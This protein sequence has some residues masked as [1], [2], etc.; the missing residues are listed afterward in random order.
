MPSLEAVAANARKA[1]A[2]AIAVRVVLPL[3]VGIAL[4]VGMAV[5]WTAPE[6]SDGQGAGLGVAEAWA[7]QAPTTLT[8][9]A[10][11]HEQ[12]ARNNCPEDFTGAS[13]RVRHVNDTDA[14]GKPYTSCR[15]FGGPELTVSSQCKHKKGDTMKCWEHHRAPG[16]VDTEYV[17]SKP[18]ECHYLWSLVLLFI[19][20]CIICIGGAGVIQLCWVEV[21]Q[22][23]KSRQLAAAIEMKAADKLADPEAFTSVAAVPPTG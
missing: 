6:V 3:V 21:K 13:C 9:G 16:E 18:K 11:P 8:A 5:G 7:T 17:F 2:R 4:L 19:P 22:E 10:C 23:K 14:A 15:I 20:V 12:F 1:G